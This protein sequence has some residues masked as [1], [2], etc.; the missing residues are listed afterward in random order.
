MRNIIKI[1]ATIVNTVVCLIGIAVII[2]VVCPR[3]EKE[4]LTYKMEKEYGWENISLDKDGNIWTY[5]AD[6]AVDEDMYHCAGTFVAGFD[7]MEQLS[8]EVHTNFMGEDVKIATWTREQGQTFRYTPAGAL[9][10]YGVT[11]TLVF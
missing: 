11:K 6:I 5:E 9:L 3:F 7:H 2:L 10:G 4:L 1:M 8:M